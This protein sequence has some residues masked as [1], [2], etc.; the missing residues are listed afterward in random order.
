MYKYIYIIYIYLLHVPADVAE[1]DARGELGLDA[2]DLGAEGCLLGIWFCV[3]GGGWMAVTG[4]IYRISLPGSIHMY[5]T[6]NHKEQ[7]KRRRT[8]E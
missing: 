1:R 2:V 6:N 3:V 8:L 5:N 4:F 7:T